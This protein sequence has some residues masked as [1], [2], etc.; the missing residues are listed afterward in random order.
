[1]IFYSA[2]T[3][4][5]SGSIAQ[6][7]ENISTATRRKYFEGQGRFVNNCQ[8]RQQTKV[9]ADFLQNKTTSTQQSLE[10]SLVLCNLCSGAQGST[11]GDRQARRRQDLP[12]G[13]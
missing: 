6:I 2:D 5:N 4:R 3:L 13:V 10:F 9:I 1:M 8:K 12:A 11:Q 7:N